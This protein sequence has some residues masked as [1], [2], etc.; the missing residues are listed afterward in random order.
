LIMVDL[1]RKIRATQARQG[2]FSSH[3]LP[4]VVPYELFSLPSY[5]LA[6]DITLNEQETG[7]TSAT[8]RREQPTVDWIFTQQ[9][10]AALFSWFW[11]SA[12][13]TQQAWKRFLT[14]SSDG[15]NG[16]NALVSPLAV[17]SLAFPTARSSW[18]AL[19]VEDSG[20][21]VNL[22]QSHTF[23]FFVK[24]S[25]TIYPAMAAST[26]NQMSNRMFMAVWAEA[27]AD[28]WYTYAL[29]DFEYAVS[30]YAVGPSNFAEEDRILLNLEAYGVDG[31]L[32]SGNYYK[33]DGAVSGAP[34]SPT[35]WVHYAIC[36]EGNQSSIYINGQRVKSVTNNY[37][38]D[39]RPASATLY[40]EVATESDS[41]RDEGEDLA[42]EIPPLRIHGLRFT[43]RALYSGTSFTPP[44][45]ITDFA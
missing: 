20:I 17:A 32:D 2:G 37:L 36:Q 7:I 22:N 10:S 43:P 38:S 5:R 31:D 13:A 28:E 35:A 11:V 24:I 44:T 4:G 41:Y 14:S 30:S 3:V 29:C 34:I 12:V 25:D 45:S 26:F 18:T 42:F 16:T 21:P 39:E 6:P 1:N 19:I 23:E 15:P 27:G 9:L 33:Y 40:F 8:L